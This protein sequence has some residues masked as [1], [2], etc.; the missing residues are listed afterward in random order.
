MVRRIAGDAQQVER[1]K[2]S[3]RRI[4][5]A[6]AKFALTQRHSVAQMLAGTARFQLIEPSDDEM[7][8]V[9]F[10][11]P[12]AAPLDGKEILQRTIEKATISLFPELPAV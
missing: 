9:K 3:F 10:E 6:K 2:A 1:L 7:T 11:D 8:H 5:A 12:T 4:L